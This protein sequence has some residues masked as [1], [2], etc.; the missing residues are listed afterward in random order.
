MKLVE[1]EAEPEERRKL[2]NSINSFLVQAQ[3]T[4]INF[5]HVRKEKANLNGGK[6]IISFQPFH[7]IQSFVARVESYNFVSI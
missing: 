7:F 1:V 2:L 6:E 4:R 3:N 5:D